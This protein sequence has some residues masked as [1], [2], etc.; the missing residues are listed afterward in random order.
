MRGMRFSFS[1][2]EGSGHPDLWS[3]EIP[4]NLNP[5]ISMERNEVIC[6]GW[7][8]SAPSEVRLL[9]EEDFLGE[10]SRESCELD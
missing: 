5:T 2:V 7:I 10:D 3:S 8:E 4:L 1:S 6:A 9:T